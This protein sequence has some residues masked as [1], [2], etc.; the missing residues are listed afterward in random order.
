MPALPPAHV[1]VDPVRPLRQRL[2]PLRRTLLWALVGTGLAHAGPSS[3]V[4]LPTAPLL[5]QMNQ[6]ALERLGPKK[7]IVESR[8]LDEQGRYRLRRDGR[9]VAEGA[10]TALPAFEAWTPGKRHFEVDFTAQTQAGRYELEVQVG[11]AR[12][13]SLPVVVR[14]QALFGRAAGALLSYFRQSRHTDPGD[15]RRRIFDTQRHVDVW[16]GWRDA[17]GDTGKYLSHL[18]YANHFN[19]QQAP[20]A[21]WVLA[22][23]AHQAPGLYRQ[24]GLLRQVRDEAFWGADYLHRVLDPEGYFYTTVFDQWGKPGAE[25]MVVGYEGEEGT[26]TRGYRSAFRAGGGLAIAALA[27]AAQLSHSAGQR[28]QFRGATYL[29]DAERAFAHLQA[30]NLAYC[31]DGQEN[32]IDDYTALLAAVELHRATA[33]A[34]YLEAARQ[35]ARQLLARQDERGQFYSDQPGQ[36]PYYHAVE[37][38]LPLIS[39]VH[40]LSIEQDPARAAPVREALS[41]ALAHQLALDTEVANPYAYARQRFKLFQDGAI[42]EPERTGFFIPHRNETGYWWQGESARL[43]SLATAAVLAGREVDPAPQEAY[44]IQPPLA[45]FAQAQIDW[46]LGRNPY[47]LSMFYGLGQRNPPTALDSAG[48]MLRGG[49]SNGITGADGRD[50]GEGIAFAPGP[51]DHQWRWIEQ[52]LPHSAWMLLAAVE[53]AGR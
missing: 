22:Y 10:L 46:T 42:Q 52:W 30:H 6:L 26:Y 39:L 5:V 19:P 38:G 43:A 7:A 25:R 45:R 8:G 20:M 41:R 51:E 48:V 14:D 9:I 31:A 17:G 21:A 35:R 3:T 44:G 34:T 18:G 40:Y 13:R 28:G 32:V 23:T 16:G 12:A 53:M 2:A 33:R 36:R 1:R 4:Q 49:I 15:H 47:G 37:A 27:R 29:A 50:T 24:A 11:T